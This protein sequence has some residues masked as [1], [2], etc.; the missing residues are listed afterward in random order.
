[1]C[2]C[3]AFGSTSWFYQPE[4]VGS[5]PTTRN[6]NRCR[7]MEEK[8]NMSLLLQVRKQRGTEIA[9]TQKV[10]YNN[11]KWIVP[12]Q[13]S[14]KKYEVILGLGN[15]SC[16][17]PDYAE[18]QIKCKHIF[19]VEVTITKH[20]DTEGNVTI[21]Q[22][23]RITYPQNWKVYD[24]SQTNEKRLFLKLLSELCQ[25]VD[26]PL[27]K[28]GRPRLPLKNMVFASA[29]KVYSTF[30]LRRFM[31]DFDMAIKEGYATKS[32][33]YRSVSGYMQDEALTPILHNLIALSAMPLKSIETKFAIDSTGFRTSKFTEYCKDKHDTKK[34]HQWIKAHICTGISTHIITGVE[35][36]EE[37]SADS[38]QFI[39]LINETA[40]IGF[41]VDEVSADKAYNSKY[42]YNAVQAI[43]G[44]AYI[45][46]RSNITAL[47]N[48]GNKARLWRK[49]FNYF[50]Y[51]R[52]EFLE[53]YHLRSNIE[54]TI[55][56]IKSKFTDLIR[57]KD[58]TA[59]VNEVLLKVL[60][61]NIVV[62]IH[63]MN[64]LGI[65]PSFCSSQE[66][67]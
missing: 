19:A 66:P 48:T 56:M 50:I 30:S 46:Y 52:D 54:S 14:D 42:N 23:K 15:S 25:D 21:T 40:R 37:Y 38:P 16:N 36:G 47:S 29:L 49:M 59:Q 24:A 13:S 8:S 45:P 10:S 6:P 2:E 22:T 11:G 9:K 3:G 57:S 35:I 12:S 62:L 28:F 32:C 55:N 18:R 61:H 60:C 65:E 53:H 5:N 39:P 17:C 67:N 34:Q 64:E 26:E 58:K 20:L 51:N 31:T 1:M 44:T 4:D 27:Y 7:H 63:E 33:S 43:G 41:D